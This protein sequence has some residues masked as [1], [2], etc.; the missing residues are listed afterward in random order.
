M[1]LE[2]TSTQKWSYPAVPTATVWLLTVR[3]ISHNKK[4][5][6]GRL[7]LVSN[8]PEGMAWP[9]PSPTT[10]RI[11]FGKHWVLFCQS[12]FVTKRT[13]GLHSWSPWWNT[14]IK[15]RMAETRNGQ[16]WYTHLD[17]GENESRHDSL[18]P[19]SGRLC[20]EWRH[21][22]CGHGGSLVGPRKQPEYMVLFFI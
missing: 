14:N 21:K 4:Q 6:Q 20:S 18:M 19:K 22:N 1:S 5:A 2:S 17:G 3:N 10:N 7:S 15:I 12:C 13:R 16:E 9:Q 8:H 11:H